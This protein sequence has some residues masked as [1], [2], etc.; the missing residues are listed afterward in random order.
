MFYVLAM[1]QNQGNGP[2][3]KIDYSNVGGTN[4]SGATLEYENNAITITFNDSKDCTAAKNKL[5][6]KVT[7][8][9]TNKKLIVNF[10]EATVE[11]SKNNLSSCSENECRELAEEIGGSY[12]YGMENGSCYIINN[13]TGCYL[14][15][16]CEES[17]NPDC[18]L[19]SNG[20]CVL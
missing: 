11:C 2:S 1:S 6:D 3:G 17:P 16:Y 18:H 7:D 12:V 8:D 5:G 10:G 14:P 15:K 4:P 9:C 13:A 19:D 20:D